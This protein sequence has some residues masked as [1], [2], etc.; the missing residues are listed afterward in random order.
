M[1]QSRLPIWTLANALGLGV[2]F[3]AILQMTMLVEYGLDFEKYWEFIPPDQSVRA[4]A[5]RLVSSLLGG[6][7]FGAAQVLF[8]RSRSVRVGSWI[9]ATTVGF[10]LIL[11]VEWPLMAVG[12]WG[13]IPGPIEPISITVG[14]GSFAGI[15]QYLAL[16]KQ[17]I[18]ASRWLALWIGGLVASL[19]P[20][21]LVF[22]SLEEAGL[23]ISWP[24][25]TFLSGFIVAG[26]AA[27]ISGRALL[28]SISPLQSR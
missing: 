23:S 12:I 27:L 22:I 26:V 21:A 3:V 6:A 8:L 16:R 18:V 28:A 17:G 19:V 13:R 7:I 14:G 24:V 2:S 25:E 1:K 20:A 9:L 10:A 11:A 5:A 4:Y 15:M